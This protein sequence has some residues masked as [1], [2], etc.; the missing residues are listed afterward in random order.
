M[1]MHYRPFFQRACNRLLINVLKDPSKLFDYLN[2]FAGSTMLS[3]I[4]GY[5]TNDIHD[6]L[7]RNGER[8]L[9]TLEA[10]TPEKSV[11]IELFP[12]ILSLPN[13]FPGVSLQKNARAARRTLHEYVE[14]P[15]QFTTDRLQQDPSFPGMLS[16]SIRR[17]SNRNNS[18]SK[19]AMKQV[20]AA[21][22]TDSLKL[23]TASTLLVFVL[24]MVM[25]PDV[26]RRAQEE[27]RTVTGNDRLP[28]LEDRS[29]LPYF[30][31]I[32]R[33]V[34]RWHPVVPLAVP[35]AAIDDD[36]YDNYFIFKG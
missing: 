30:G 8:A 21:A 35:H 33:E 10:I 16:D 31:A 1:T 14:K 4:Y 5:E 26:Q 32:I 27:M 29:S 25:H 19:E 7:V 13:W 11:L 9:T 15:Y 3:S 18:F 36:V 2:L 34:M 23:Q 12:F 24:A 22:F 6:P 17:F 28:V 20:S